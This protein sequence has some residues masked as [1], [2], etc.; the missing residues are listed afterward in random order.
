MSTVKIGKR[1]QITIPAIAR[2]QLNIH[3][4]DHLT[5]DIQNDMLILLPE[6]KDYAQYMTGLHK[7]IWEG[8]DPQEYIDRERNDTGK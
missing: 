7:E 8:I 1:N 6:P 5:V 4:G 2:K 3:S